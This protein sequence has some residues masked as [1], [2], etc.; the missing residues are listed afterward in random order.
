MEVQYSL[1][2]C[3]LASVDLASDSHG[4]LYGGGQPINLFRYTYVENNKKG[5]FFPHMLLMF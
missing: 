4:A 2:L 1:L 3:P 5:V